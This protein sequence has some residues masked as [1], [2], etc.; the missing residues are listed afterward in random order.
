MLITAARAVL[1][2][3][4]VVQDREDVATFGNEVDRGI[5][6]PYGG[7]HFCTDPFVIVIAP[8]SRR[9]WTNDRGDDAAPRAQPALE[10]ADVMQQR[11]G[12]LSSCGV[13]ACIEKASSDLDRV[14]P[15][16]AR[17]TTPEFSLGVQQL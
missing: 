3:I 11:S 10:L 17:L 14:A 1:G 12:H 9:T 8:E 6:A 13:R 4:T 5:F 16:D 7:K 2:P 15:I